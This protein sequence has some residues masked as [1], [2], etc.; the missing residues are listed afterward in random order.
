MAGEPERPFE[1]RY[2]ID[3]ARRLRPCESGIESDRQER[4][5]QRDF[6]HAAA[7]MKG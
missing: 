2:R 5:G 7:P 6:R 1:C 4:C 3:Q